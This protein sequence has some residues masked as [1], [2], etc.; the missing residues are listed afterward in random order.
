[1]QSNF[2]SY[3]YVKFLA[4]EKEV[5]REPNKSKDWISMVYHI[6]FSTGVEINKEK[7]T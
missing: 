3:S 1:M 7:E 5:V 4:E 2:I 6:F